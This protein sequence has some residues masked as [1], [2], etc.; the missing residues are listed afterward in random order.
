MLVVILPFPLINISV[1]VGVPPL[2]ITL[3]LLP[4][5]LVN[6]AIGVMHTALSRPFSFFVLSSIPDTNGLNCYAS[7]FS[8]D[9]D[10]SF[11]TDEFVS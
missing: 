3:A 8:F 2:T 4:S 5:A 1:R 11:V 7:I 10:G 6:A 9:E